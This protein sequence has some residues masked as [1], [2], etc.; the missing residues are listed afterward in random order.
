MQFDLIQQR[1]DPTRFVLIAVYR[2]PYDPARH[3]DTPHYA[4]WRDAVAPMMAEP[5]RSVTYR[6]A[7]GDAGNRPLD[8]T[9]R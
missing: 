8:G 9:A 7:V 1:D 4:T 5:R 6:E 2:T 3:K